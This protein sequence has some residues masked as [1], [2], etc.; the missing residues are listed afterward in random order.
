LRTHRFYTGP[1]IKLKHDFWLHDET[2]I[3][4]WN[5][6]LRFRAGQQ[7][8]LF[9]GEKTERLYKL[10]AI[11]KTEAHLLLITE[12]ERQLP[13]RHVYLFWS[14]LKKDNNEFVLQ[15]AT[16]LG[17]SNFVPILSER[18]I[19]KSF[20]IDRAQKIVIEASEQCGRSN[21]PYV[22]EP[23]DLD[24]AIEEYK[25]KI[26]LYVCDQPNE[27][28]SPENNKLGVFIGPEG[29]WSEREYELFKDKNMSFFS[30]SDHTLR[31]ETA[32]IA[33]SSKLLQ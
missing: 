11:A 20:N 17:V 3:W 2:L 10:E 30:I 14:L 33:A 12:L 7:I 21:I 6:V 26:P 15:K 4:Q 23:L 24:T 18:S 28:Q 31:A 13:S 9:D 1:E 16:E 29:G 32:A 27:K 22:R 19:R 5:K 8:I 25:G